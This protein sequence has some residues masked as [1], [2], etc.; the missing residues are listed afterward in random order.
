MARSIPPKRRCIATISTRPAFAAVSTILRASAAVGAIGFST[1]TCA[2]ALE[3]LDGELA[4]QM[5]RREDSDG[6]GTL[7]REHLVEIRVDLGAARVVGPERTRDALGLVGGAA[8]QR[9]N[10]GVGDAAQRGNMRALGNRTSA[11]NRDPDH[12]ERPR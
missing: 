6:V 8:L 3:R 1:S 2:P 5:I 10:L 11:G 4:M 9:D 12:R 7:A